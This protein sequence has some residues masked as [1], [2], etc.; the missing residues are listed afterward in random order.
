MY[1]NY[2]EKYIATQWIKQICARVQNGTRKNPNGNGW[3]QNRKTRNRAQPK[4]TL[5]TL[6]KFSA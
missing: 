1:N 2:K 5:T 4:Q 6:M 3:F